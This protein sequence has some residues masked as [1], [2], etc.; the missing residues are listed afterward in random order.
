LGVLAFWTHVLFYTLIGT[1]HYIFSSIPWRIQTT[2][3]VASAG[4]VIP[5]AAGTANFLL[6][7][8]GAWYQLRTSYTLPFYLMSI[9]FYFTVSNGPSISVEGIR[10]KDIVNGKLSLMINAYDKGNQK[11]FIITGSETPQSI[12]FWVWIIIILFIGWAIY[13]E[14]TS[15]QV[16]L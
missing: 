9:I 4:M 5:V 15:A 13:Y 12:P 14:I 7:F 2:A 3:I 16:E 10:I 11:S 1:H 8:K 6:T